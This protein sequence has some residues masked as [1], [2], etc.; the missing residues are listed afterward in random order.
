MHIPLSLL[1]DPLAFVGRWAE[2]CLERNLISFPAPSYMFPA[3]MGGENHV[4][5]QSRGFAPF[6]SPK[7]TIHF[8]MTL[9]SQFI[10]QINF[11]RKTKIRL[12]QK[13][14]HSTGVKIQNKSLMKS[15]YYSKTQMKSQKIAQL[16]PNV[17]LSSESCGAQMFLQQ[18]RQ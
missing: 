5:T 17:D 4:K 14:E 6:K 10:S 3:Q 1:L 2:I 12:R 16:T 8:F 18:D 9:K 7:Q 13:Q 11:D 15:A